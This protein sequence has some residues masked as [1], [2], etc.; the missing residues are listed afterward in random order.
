[1][2]IKPETSGGG[3]EGEDTQNNITL[4]QASFSTEARLAKGGRVWFGKE[5]ERDGSSK[6]VSLS[7]YTYVCLYVCSYS[8]GS[9]FGIEFSKV[10]F[11]IS[12][13]GSSKVDWLLGR[14]ATVG[15]NESLLK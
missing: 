5:R 8:K 14:S 4:R 1:M 12:M 15:T 3:E 6:L 13:N 2:L 9:V 11:S 10:G 7:I